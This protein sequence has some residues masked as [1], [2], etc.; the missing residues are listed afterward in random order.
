MRLK[1]R[2]VLFAFVAVAAVAQT[3][4][5]PS[6]FEVASVKQSDPSIRGMGSIR[7]GPG[8]DSPGQLTITNY[9][10]ISI[11]TAAFDKHHRWL[12]VLPDSLPR[13]RYD[14]V[15]KVP[16][17]ATKDQFNLMFQNLLVERFGLVS[18]MEVRE[19]PA[20]DLV[21][22]KDGPKIAP[23]SVPLDPSRSVPPPGVSGPLWLRSL[24]KDKDGWPILPPEAVGHFGPSNPSNP[25]I[26]REAYRRQPLSQFSSTLEDWFSRPVLDKTGLAGIYSFDLTYAAFDTTE[27]N[28]AMARARDADN[29]AESM[30]EVR[31]RDA[32]AGERY[33]AGYFAAM[34][35]QLGL[36]IL[37]SKTKVEVLVVDHMN[38]KPTEN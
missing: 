34:E 33:Q 17:G 13:D 19:V 11:I 30:A 25:T 12:Y 37:P 10:L 5:P 3:P 16:A 32:A 26:R 23:V 24:P 22:A 8:T 36:K 1:S 29:S 27:V 31:A 28:A 21:V 7:G 14:I 2:R 6:S 18:H 35:R 9:P 4:A 38:S 20:F 15:A